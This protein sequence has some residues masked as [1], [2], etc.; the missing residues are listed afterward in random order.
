M[1]SRR[2]TT[3]FADAER[4]CVCAHPVIHGARIANAWTAH[5]RRIS[6]RAEGLNNA[7]GSKCHF[8][9][10][11]N[12]PWKLGSVVT[13]SIRRYGC[14]SE[15]AI[16]LLQVPFRRPGLNNRRMVC[17]LRAEGLTRVSSLR[18]RPADHDPAARSRAKPAHIR[19]TASHRAPGEPLRTTVV[20]TAYLGHTRPYHS[21][22]T[23]SAASAW[24]PLPRRNRERDSWPIEASC[25]N[26][27]GRPALALRDGDGHRQRESGH[28][29]DVAKR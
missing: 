9:R 28:C 29:G 21:H 18:L 7:F 20:R 16:G 11:L 23:G 26:V 14:S 12:E 22:R 4:A 8:E 3:Q 13:Q 1:R 2:A 17:A 19:N 27:S 6:Y 24:R 15:S 5:P 10:A 25:F